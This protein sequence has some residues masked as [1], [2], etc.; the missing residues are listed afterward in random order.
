V[1]KIMIVG[2]SCFTLWKNRRHF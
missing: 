2:S 1:P